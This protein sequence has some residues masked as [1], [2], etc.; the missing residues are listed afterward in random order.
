[1]KVD[2]DALDALDAVS[3]RHW[4]ERYCSRDLAVE[5]K[6]IT[7]ADLGV[8]YLEQFINTKKE[9]SPET[10][11]SLLPEKLAEL[12]KM[13]L[14]DSKT[15]TL[16]SKT[17]IALEKSLEISLKQTLNIKMKEL[18]ELDSSLKSFLTFVS[19]YEKSRWPDFLKLMMYT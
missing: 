1:V 12:A 4:I 16:L 11:D 17:K 14:H 6:Y 18:K 15:Y 8:R 3:F 7:A 19:S 10:I 2:Y 5:R 9:L 13:W